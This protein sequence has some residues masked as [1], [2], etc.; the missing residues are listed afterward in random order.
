ME[1]KVSKSLYF[2]KI[3]Y[4]RLKLNWV[5]FIAVIA[6]L[7]IIQ[8]NLLA[9]YYSNHIME[10]VQYY[11]IA[12]SAIHVISGIAGMLICILFYNRWSKKH[13]YSINCD[14]KTEYLV[15]LTILGIIIITLILIDIL[16]PIIVRFFAYLSL[17]G[18]GLIG[19]EQFVP[20]AK[21][22][23]WDLYLS[24]TTIVF[25]SGMAFAIMQTMST[26]W[27]LS[28]IGI[29][30]IILT[31]Y[32][33]ANLVQWIFNKA[34][35]EQNIIENIYKIKN[36]VDNSIGLVFMLVFNVISRLINKKVDFVR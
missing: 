35:G 8:C 27:Y 13:N 31:F 25:L 32:A 12:T 14:D 28:I 29:V 26:K 34:I 10:L 23:F 4:T 15:D 21:D 2:R 9:T 6:A 7:I 20:L 30:V 3:L 22:F 5:S 18:K 33:S 19:G 11:T 1:T 17:S 16:L 36:V 24:I